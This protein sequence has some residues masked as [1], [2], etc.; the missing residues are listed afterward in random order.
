MATIDKS[1]E[2]IAKDVVDSLYWDSRV[3]ASKMGVY[4]NDGIVTLSG[5]LSSYSERAA[6]S[7]DA[8]IISGVRD[9]KNQLKVDV[10]KDVPS[11]NE[12]R[13]R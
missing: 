7:E 4:V 12:I 9:V 13:S 8:W 1:D 10:Q 3:D 11:D 5:T 6:A 2:G